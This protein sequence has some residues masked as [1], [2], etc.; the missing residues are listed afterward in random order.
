MSATP[1]TDDRM[2]EIA[3]A[4][5]KDRYKQVDP[6]DAIEMARKLHARIVGLGFSGE[7]ATEF[8]SAMLDEKIKAAIAD[9]SQ[10]PDANGD[11]FDLSRDLDEIF[12]RGGE[13]LSHIFR[14]PGD[15]KGK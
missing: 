10:K 8:A 13:L 12:R 4:L 7:E 6:S 2:K 11:D 1:I 14:R 15:K 3:L 5:L 9:G